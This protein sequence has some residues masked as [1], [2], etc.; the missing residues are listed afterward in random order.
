MDI[1]T[2]GTILATGT[3]GAVAALGLSLVGL[4]PAVNAEENS[5]T[6]A[7]EALMSP[8]KTLFPAPLDVDGLVRWNFEVQPGISLEPIR[9][10]TVTKI[11]YGRMTQVNIIETSSGIYSSDAITNPHIQYPG[12]AVTPKREAQAMLLW[13][14]LGWSTLAPLSGKSFVTVVP[15]DGGQLVVTD[16]SACSYTAK[17]VAC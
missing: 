8:A 17:S 7:M 5:A 3:L 14:G 15:F 4:L 1:R 2:I 13:N 10:S 9:Q 12:I 16:D 11:A 6:T